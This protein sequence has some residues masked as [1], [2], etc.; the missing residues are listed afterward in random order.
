MRR[1]GHP[2]E[3]RRRVLDLLEAGRPVAEVARDLAISDQTI[4]TWRRRTA[5]IERGAWNDDGRA[6]RAR[7]RGRRSAGSRPSG[8]STAAPRSC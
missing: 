1:R 4:S 7:R 5:S 8:P 6:R 2:P 3:F